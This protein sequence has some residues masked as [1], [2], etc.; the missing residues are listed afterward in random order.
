MSFL[1]I[2]RSIGFICSIVLLAPTAFAEQYRY[3]NDAGDFVVSQ[4]QP[5]VGV[6]YAVL[7]DEGIYQYLVHATALVM[8][9]LKWQAAATPEPGHAQHQF[10]ELSQFELPNPYAGD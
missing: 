6:S 8:P 10:V 5:P 9:E 3:Q 2:F 4:S 7:D 1:R